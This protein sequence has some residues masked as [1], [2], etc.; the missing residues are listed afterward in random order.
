MTK[1]EFLKELESLLPDIPLEEREEALRYYNG[2]FEDAGE[3]Q[4]EEIIKEI[5]SPSKVAAIIKRILIAIL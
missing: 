5:G 1:L 2:Y 4:E 3:E